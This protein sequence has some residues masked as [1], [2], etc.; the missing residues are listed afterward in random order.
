MNIF[1][2]DWAKIQALP[3][4]HVVIGRIIHTWVWRQMSCWTDGLRKVT[5]D[6][7]SPQKGFWCLYSTNDKIIQKY[8]EHDNVTYW[9]WLQFSA[10][11]QVFHCFSLA[12]MDSKLAIIT[13]IT[14]SILMGGA[15][16][17]HNGL[18]IYSL[19][20]TAR[21]TF[22]PWVTDRSPPQTN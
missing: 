21:E 13:A 2:K 22:P 7:F 9:L 6:R 5:G 20:Q 18:K 16:S 15:C 11:Y 8:F 19:C 14:C 3:S 10:C 1:P 12:T 17:C 4:S